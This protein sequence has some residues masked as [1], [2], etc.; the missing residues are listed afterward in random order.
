MTTFSFYFSHPQFILHSILRRNRLLPDL[1]STLPC[2]LIETHPTMMYFNSI[3][4]CIPFIL[5]SLPAVLSSPA[6]ITAPNPILGGLLGGGLLSPI[7]AVL[8][9][10]PAREAPEALKTNDIH[11]VCAPLNRGALL[12]CET[13]FDGAFPLV[14]QLSEATGYRLTLDAINGILCT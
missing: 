9:L 6:P 10:L 5:L 1:W 8:N 14:V 4:R 7:G 13:L 2:D 12:C 3:R 11:P